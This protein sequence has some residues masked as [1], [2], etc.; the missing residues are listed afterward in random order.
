MKIDIQYTDAGLKV[1]SKIVSTYSKCCIDFIDESFRFPKKLK[2]FRSLTV[3]DY[4]WHR[5]E[6]KMSK[7]G[8]RDLLGT[9]DCERLNRL[10]N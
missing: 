8:L 9:I 5:Y 3:H 7:F 10:Q 2:T 6:P 1:M 4:D